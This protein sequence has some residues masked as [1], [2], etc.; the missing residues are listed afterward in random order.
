MKLHVRKPNWSYDEVKQF[1][2][3]INE[4]H[5]P[6]IVIHQYPELLLV[7]NLAGFHVTHFYKNELENI[8]QILKPNQSL[9]ISCHSFDEI[10]LLSKFDYCF[11]SPVFNSISKIGYESTFSI[12]EIE[13]GIQQNKGK[14]IVA[15]GGI[16]ASNIKILN[17]L[18]VFGAALLGSIWETKNP[19]EQWNEIQKLIRF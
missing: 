14:N 2:K 8:K 12:P 5:H 4:I 10:Q 7:F 16:N 17:Q 1:I 15:L 18:E 11:I 3:Q 13:N 6:K 19:L 9:S